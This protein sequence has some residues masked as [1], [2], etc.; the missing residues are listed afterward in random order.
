M[1]RREVYRIREKREEEGHREEEEDEKNQKKIKEPMK[2]R[3]K[4]GDKM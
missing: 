4:K 1:G 2:G 3:E